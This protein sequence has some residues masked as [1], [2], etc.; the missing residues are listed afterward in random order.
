MA[1]RLPP[2]AQPARPHPVDIGDRTEAIV[3]AAL[4]RRGYRV[5]RPLSSNQ[6]Y[7]LVLDLGADFL[8]VRCK[9]GGLRK[10]AIVF[11]TPT[12]RTCS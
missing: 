9:T 10:G 8:R 1:Y 3:V 11:L 5:L 4:V 2:P 12:R 7:D 6:R